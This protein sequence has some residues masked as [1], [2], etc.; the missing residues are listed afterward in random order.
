[1]SCLKIAIV[2][3]GPKIIDSSYGLKI[4]NFLKQYGTVHCR[5][6]GTMG[7]TAVIDA[8]LQDLIDISQKLLP[9]ESVKYYKN[10]NK[11]F[12]EDNFEDNLKDNFDVIFLLNY[13][14][15]SITGHTFGFK[16]FRNSYNEKI[17]SIYFKHET[18]N[19]IDNTND[20]K[21]NNSNNNSN[22]NAY[23]DN[24]KISPSFIQIER[25]GE[26]DGTIIPW[27]NENEK[28]NC[29][30]TDLLEKFNLNLVNPLNIIEKHFPDKLRYSSIEKVE[31]EDND[32]L[33]IREVHGV[34]PNENIFVN[35][36]VIGKSTSSN[37]SIIFKNGFIIDVSG[38]KVK[39]HG[40]EKLGKID[41]EK[42][43]IKTG[44]LRKNLV[45]PRVV[46][47]E[48]NSSLI[49]DNNID[50]NIFEIAIVDHAA[51]D[52]Y[53]LNNCDLV[54]TVGDDT[55]LVGSDILYRFNIPVIGITDG[56]LDKV[57]E[58]GFKAKGSRIIEVEKG[59]DDIIGQEIHK[60]LFNSKNKISLPILFN[61]IKSK[62]SKNSIKEDIIENLLSKI[63]KIIKDKDLNYKLTK[64]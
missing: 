40:I 7:R 30:T 32:L 20:N 19:N 47:I 11:T 26:I 16:V 8:N 25:P 62:Q 52:I 4:I 31:D 34:S 35:G 41:L 33:Y 48:E 44:L 45:K 49:K 57:V 15:S 50:N 56:D 29:L 53:S 61:V 3:H 58:L 60:K 36:V 9:S 23:K 10:Y 24:A 6:G 2:V 27:F 18:M 55:T 38:G 51:Y 17:D 64:L 37:L 12:F 54:L 28:I 63:I 59:F 21:N 46:D 39:K 42:A 43:I 14:K 13:G 1:M 5:L 22:N